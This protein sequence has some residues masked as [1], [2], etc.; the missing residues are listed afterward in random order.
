MPSQTVPLASVILCT[1]NPNPARMLRCLEGL[2]AQT[3]PNELW[4]LVVVDNRSATPVEKQF[5]F[6]W[7]PNARVVIEQKLGLTPARLCGI[8]ESSGDILVLVDDDNVLHPDYLEKA[9]AIAG[10]KTFLGAWGGSCEAVFESPPPAW[11]ERYWGCLAIREIAED[12]WSNEPRNVGTLPIGAGM[13]VRRSVALHYKN[14]I[15][16]GKRLIQLD[17]TG[18]SLLSGGDQDLAACST[19]LG[20]GSGVLT[21]L[22]LQHI[23]PSGRLEAEY[24]CKLMEG[25]AFS[26]TLLDFTYGTRPPR[27]TWIRRLKEAIRL[28]QCKNPH[29]R[30]LLATFRGQRN[31]RKYIAEHV[32]DSDSRSKH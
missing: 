6:H 16:S 7:H 19:E 26:G 32:D 2:K 4:E 22:R 15:E 14:I 27:D 28:A 18:N 5:D 12:R 11:T 23:I 8:S 25:I 13:C 21:G 10:T 3:L 17:R 9:V 30:I 20:L 1:H 24:L 31:A 29:R